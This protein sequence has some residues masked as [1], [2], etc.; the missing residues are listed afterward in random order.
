MSLPNL[1]VAAGQWY[2]AIGLLVALVFA[3]VLVQRVE[4][5]ARGGSLAFRLA[6]V[7]GATL[8]WPLILLRSLRALR[9]GGAR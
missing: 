7:P 5:T 6:I 4:P 1:I 9:P 3:T 2:L 8:L